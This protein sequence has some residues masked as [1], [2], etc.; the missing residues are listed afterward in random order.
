MLM[1]LRLVVM[2]VTAP[3]AHLLL[4]LEHASIE[5]EAEENKIDP[6]WAQRATDGSHDR[7][8]SLGRRV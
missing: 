1:L 7:V 5:E 6:N 8:D 3:S 4:A 2:V